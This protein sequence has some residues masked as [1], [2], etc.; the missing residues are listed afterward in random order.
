[1]LELYSSGRLTYCYLFEQRHEQ[2]IVRRKSLED[3]SI[4]GEIDQDGQ[5][6]V[7]YRLEC[8]YRLARR[9]LG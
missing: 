6:I 2:D 9:S 4:V 7:G 1:M 5:R 3:L 8:S